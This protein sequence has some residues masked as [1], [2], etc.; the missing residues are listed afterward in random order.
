MALV[1]QMMEQ[2]RG[3]EGV[4]GHG[5]SWKREKPQGLNVGKQRMY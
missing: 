2:V 1:L 3:V 4:G 5:Y